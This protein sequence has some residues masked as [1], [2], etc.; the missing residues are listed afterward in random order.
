MARYTNQEL[1]T[2]IKTVRREMQ[3]G[4]KVVH[5]ELQPLRDFVLVQQELAKQKLVPPIQQAG[6][7]LGVPSAVWDIIKWLL[8]ILAGVLG[9]RII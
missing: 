7:T 3:D 1:A 4:F 6:S 8:L 9:V 5:N 2:E